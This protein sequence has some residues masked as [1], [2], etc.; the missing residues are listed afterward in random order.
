MPSPIRF[1]KVFSFVDVRAALAEIERQPELWGEITLRQTYPGT[2][3]ADT[4]TIFI[5]GPSSPAGAFD[6]VPAHFYPAV[7]KLPECSHLVSLLAE[8]L[9]AKE[10]G[11]VMVVKLKAGGHIAPHVDEGK[12]AEHYERFHFVLDSDEGN[13]FQCA[14][15]IEWMKPGTAWWFDHRVEHSV[16]NASAR[17]RIHLIVDLV[18]PQFAPA[19]GAWS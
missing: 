19:R 14:D 18:T 3:H 12:Y 4:E 13:V 6:E 7:E 5:R 10:L 16:T 9:N 11:R 2:A 15:R 8:S 1:Q 17:D